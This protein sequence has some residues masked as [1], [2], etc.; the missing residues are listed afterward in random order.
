MSFRS[1][2]ISLTMLYIYP[3]STYKLPIAP[4]VSRNYCYLLQKPF[5]TIFVGSKRVQ[6]GSI[7]WEERWI[8]SALTRK[9]IW[10]PKRMTNCSDTHAPIHNEH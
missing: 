2:C 3:V 8:S 4:I 10:D 5:R 6:K 1:Y 7:R 9:V